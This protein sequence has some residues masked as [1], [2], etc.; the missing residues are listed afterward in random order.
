MAK[1]I[2]KSPETIIHLSKDNKKFQEKSGNQKISRNIQSN[3]QRIYEK[4][5]ENIKKCLKDEKISENIEGYHKRANREKY[6]KNISYNWN[7]QRLSEIIQ[8][9]EENH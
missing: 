1:I 9:L 5:W 2:F 8:I 4:I 7:H 3:D 6:Q